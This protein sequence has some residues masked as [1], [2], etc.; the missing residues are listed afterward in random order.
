[1]MA[2]AA[3][4]IV[5]TGGGMYVVTVAYLIFLCLI[6]ARAWALLIG[7]YQH[8]DRPKVP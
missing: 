8:E 3:S 1:M 6:V 2:G 4:L 5:Q 7:I